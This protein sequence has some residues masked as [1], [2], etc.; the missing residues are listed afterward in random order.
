MAL[1]EKTIRELQQI[2][3][4]DGSDLNFTETTSIAND[5]VGYWDTLA[6]I[7]HQENIEN[8]S[9]IKTEKI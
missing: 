8:Q 9:N 4:E 3:K 6:R 1:S 2:L 5:L 7:Y